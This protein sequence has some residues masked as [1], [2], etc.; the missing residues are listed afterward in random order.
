MRCT[1]LQKLKYVEAY[2]KVWEGLVQL[3]QQIEIGAL[4]LGSIHPENNRLGYKDRN[5]M[6]VRIR[7]SPFHHFTEH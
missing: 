1:N 2:V 6:I 5:S 4:G 7:I 3:L